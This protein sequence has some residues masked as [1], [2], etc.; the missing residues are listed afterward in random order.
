MAV[1]IGKP[2][3]L[4][5]SLVGGGVNF[6]VAAPE[7]TKVELLLFASGSANEPNQIIELTPLHRSGDYWHVEVQGVGIG[8]C[9]GYRVHGP[10]SAA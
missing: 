8:C 4:G 1:S 6:S 10:V 7:A 2:W 3:P 5:S 9:Y